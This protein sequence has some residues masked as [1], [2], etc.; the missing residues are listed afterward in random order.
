VAVRFQ[1][2]EPFVL[3]ANRTLAGCVLFP[4]HVWEQTGW[5]IDTERIDP[6]Y[7]DKV[8]PLH[9]DFGIAIY[10]E[11]DVRFGQGVPM[12]ETTFKPYVYLKSDTPAIDSAEEWQPEDM[13]VIGT[14]PF[15]FEMSNESYRTNPRSQESALLRGTRREDWRGAR[16]IPIYLHQSAIHRR[17][18]IHS[19]LGR[20]LLFHTNGKQSGH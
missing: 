14:G 20:L 13:D 2:Q 1:L 10:P 11:S 4:R 3:F 9:L 5:R 6:F 8:G 15:I 12:T 19:P 17:H 7:G 18:H 16:L